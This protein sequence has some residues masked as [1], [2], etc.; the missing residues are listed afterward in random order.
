MGAQTTLPMFTGSV[1]SAL[2]FTRRKYGRCR[3][4]TTEHGPHS[5]IFMRDPYTDNNVI[6]ILLYSILLLASY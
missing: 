6:I 2:L 3:P 1:Y 4:N 5:R